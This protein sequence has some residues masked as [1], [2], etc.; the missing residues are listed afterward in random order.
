[1][2]AGDALTPRTA[3]CPSREE[4]DYYHAREHSHP[5]AKRER[6]AQSGSGRMYGRMRPRGTRFENAHAIREGGVE[7]GPSLF[8]LASRLAVLPFVEDEVS[9]THR[10]R[11]AV[12]VEW[13]PALE[14]QIGVNPRHPSS[15]SLVDFL[16]L[17]SSSSS[18]LHKQ[19]IPFT[20]F[21]L[22]WINHTLIDA[23]R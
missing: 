9:L 23:V 5:G 17:V 2:R 3:T 7:G 16:C 10:K 6:S 20:Q 15:S 12:I 22:E 18:D 21:A 11:G 13:P 19:R 4:D 1:M 14:V 8:G